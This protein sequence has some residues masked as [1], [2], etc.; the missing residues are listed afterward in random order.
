MEI[1]Q[2]IGWLGN[3][4]FVAGA[5]AMANRKPIRF[6]YFSLVGNL[7]YLTQSIVYSNWSL[8]AL[9]VIL[10]VLNLMTVRRWKS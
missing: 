5:Y 9:S 10:G 2:C 6:A 1:A 7:C 3:V 4:C 8:L